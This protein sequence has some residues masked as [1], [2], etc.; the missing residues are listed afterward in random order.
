[1]RVLTNAE[2]L[3]NFAERDPVFT[4]ADYA[5]GDER[6]LFYTHPEASCI[7]VEY[8]PRAREIAVLRSPDIDV[9]V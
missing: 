9:G 1:M 3:E 6:G 5:Q 2:V 8:P 4:G 7:G